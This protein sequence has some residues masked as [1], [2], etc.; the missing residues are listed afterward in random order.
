MRRATQ[1]AILR[2][3]RQTEQMKPPRDFVPRL[4]SG[5]PEATID[6]SNR[7]FLR[8]SAA[9]LVG[10]NLSQTS[11]AGGGQHAVGGSRLVFEN[12]D[13]VNRWQRWTTCRAARWDAVVL[14]RYVWLA[15]SR[16]DE[17]RRNTAGVCMAE[18][19]AEAYVIAPPE[20]ALWQ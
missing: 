2:Q 6:R 20:F 14:A 11:F 12:P 16:Y 8:A 19:L 15:A 7:E 4:I 9:L 10:R 13:E 17:Y 5:G 1:K 3:R 18:N